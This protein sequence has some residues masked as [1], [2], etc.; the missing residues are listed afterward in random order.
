MEASASMCWNSP[1]GKYTVSVA[2]SIIG[3]MWIADVSMFFGGRS[4]E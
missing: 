3:G 2:A 4:W 1:G